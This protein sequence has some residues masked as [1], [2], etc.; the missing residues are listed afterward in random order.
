M[1]LGH[2]CISKYDERQS[3]A[4]QHEKLIAAGLEKEIAFN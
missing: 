3:L 2:A 4:T 1:L